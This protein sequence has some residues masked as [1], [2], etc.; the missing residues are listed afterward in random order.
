MSLL[1]RFP[2]VLPLVL[3]LSFSALPLGAQ[4]PPF[5]SE[6]QVYPQN[7]VEGQWVEFGV[8]NDCPLDRPAVTRNGSLIKIVLPSAGICDPPVPFEVRVAY[9]GVLPAGTYTVEA[10]ARIDTEPYAMGSFEVREAADPAVLSPSA[11]PA[12]APSQL[13]VRIWTPDPDRDPQLCPANECEVRVGGTLV[14]KQRDSRGN[15]FITAPPHEAGFAAV[16]ITTGAVTRTLPTPL[17]YFDREDAPS[18]A[19][20]ERILFPVLVNT[21][22]GHRSQWRSEAV[23]SNPNPWF[24][25]TFN[26]IRPI[27]CPATPCGERF[28]PGE[29]DKFSGVD[30]PH[31]VALL[32]PRRDADAMSFG[33]R[34]RDVSRVAENFG[35]EIPVVRESEMSLGTTLTL[36]DVPVDPRH[37][38]KVRIY[39]LNVPPSRPIEGQLTTLRTGVAGSRTTT[40]FTLNMQCADYTCSMSP[41]YAEVDLPTAEE[42][43]RV[44]VYI[45]ADTPPGALSW[46][47]ASVTNNVTQQVTIVVPDGAGGKP[48]DPC[49]VP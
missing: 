4:F 39:A 47:F 48:C 33:L 31:G 45:A 26:S 44:N 9:R 16:T 6:I 49:R 41:A 17:Y 42:G 29:Y 23:I 34:V 8:L 30:F 10:S 43:Q 32:V 1:V 25:E 40:A 7:P 27:A 35:S 14:D 37:R 22:G 15:L 11:V 24:I 36:L 18:E 46:A 28:S 2:A 3:W 38:T 19:F 13:L 20:F 21:P 5:T 12:G